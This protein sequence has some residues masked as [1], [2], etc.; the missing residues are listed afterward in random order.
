M[1]EHLSVTIYLCCTQRPFGKHCLRLCSSLCLV[2]CLLLRYTYHGS[3]CGYK[4]AHLQASPN[5]VMD[6]WRQ[7]RF[8]DVNEALDL[9]VQ[10]IEKLV[11]RIN[12]S[13]INTKPM[14]N[15]HNQVS[16]RPLILGTYQATVTIEGHFQLWEH[17]KY[18]G[19]SSSCV[20][21]TSITSAI[22]A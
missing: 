8:Q 21:T 17:H 16:T 4:E 1:Y 13:S 19:Y 6:T 20:T 7:Q 18:N 3:S 9:T 11:R 12:R 15:N 10:R 5:C 14:N 2:R 22:A